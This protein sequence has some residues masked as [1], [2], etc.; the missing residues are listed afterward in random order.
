[1]KSLLLNST[2]RSLKQIRSLRQIAPFVRS[3]GLVKFHEVHLFCCVHLWKKVSSLIEEPSLLSI[4]P[5]RLIFSCIGK[6]SEEL[7][8]HLLQGRPLL[9]IRDLGFRLGRQAWAF[10]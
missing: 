4:K 3:L 7:N 8:L 10:C 2:E 5:V 9:K 6:N 1:M